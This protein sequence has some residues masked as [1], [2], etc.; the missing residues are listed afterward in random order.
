MMKVDTF[1]LL[2]GA[3]AL[4]GMILACSP[5]EDKKLRSL[6][7][8]KR[9]PQ[10]IL[11]SS[12]DKIQPPQLPG[13][14]PPP[15]DL[16]PS[17]PSQVILKSL[18]ESPWRDWVV[19]HLRVN[20]VSRLGNLA[21]H[22]IPPEDR[23][24]QLKTLVQYV[25]LLLEADWNRFAPIFID[26]TQNRIPTEAVDQFLAFAQE[27]LPPGQDL[28]ELFRHI[29][30]AEL[31]NL[32]QEKEPIGQLR[33]IARMGLGMANPGVMENLLD[34]FPL[35]W[36]LPLRREDLHLKNNDFPLKGPFSLVSLWL[37]DS[38]TSWGDR[39]DPHPVSLLLR[40]GASPDGLEEHSNDPFS[41]QHPLRIATSHTY[42]QRAY[43]PFDYNKSLR[44]QLI[45]ELKE[46]GAQDI[47][48]PQRQFIQ[49]LLEKNY[50]QA[51]NL[52]REYP[53]LKDPQYYALDKSLE[54]H[55][56][57]PT[58]SVIDAGSFETLDFLKA[59]GF[60]ETFLEPRNSS[61]GAY[62]DTNLLYWHAVG[63]N[64]T[65]AL[66]W[67]LAR[68]SSGWY[69]PYGPLIPEASLLAFLT[70]DRT[71][72]L[73]ILFRFGLSPERS[74]SIGTSDMVSSSVKV[75]S[76]LGHASHPAV[77]NLLLKKGADP[78]VPIFQLSQG[79]GFDMLWTETT[80]PL[81]LRQILEKSTLTSPWLTWA[82]RLKGFQT[83]PTLA[84]LEGGSLK[85]RILPPEEELYALGT[86]G[87]NWKEFA[88]LGED[89]FFV[90][91]KNLKIHV[92]MVD[93]TDNGYIPH[94][95]WV[96]GQGSGDFLIEP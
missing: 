37:Y 80:G 78:D 67:I 55:P 33:I 21:Q 26:I 5:Q 8:P 82:F 32:L 86:H 31:W 7:Q 79:D 75:T 22:H 90:L 92:L 43:R 84:Y 50:S 56:L 88:S 68:A 19:Q 13:A 46:A 62:L 2:A 11:P 93:Y 53:A 14:E 96:Y 39:P 52:I 91:D 18:P 23:E 12:G 85:T 28:S 69:F 25:D 17:V 16:G 38:L 20:P 87:E 42:Y 54:D 30:V 66:E 74:I 73:E 49:A 77:K 15:V 34:R 27:L 57:F 29:S 48:L 59:Q 40:K 24:P 36:S 64:N 65:A 89:L 9:P 4:L 41:S 83:P 10:T 95:P 70:S 63:T 35:D 81:S 76:L 51:T 44:I 61:E 71:G 1:R 58:L 6:L 94:L 60:V 3:A 72:S 47:F 45:R